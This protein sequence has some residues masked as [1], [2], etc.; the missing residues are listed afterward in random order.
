MVIALA[1]G[2]A[3]TPPPT[4]VRIQVK[5]LN[6]S[7]RD[8]F[9]IGENREDIRQGCVYPVFT[10]ADVAEWVTDRLRAPLGQLGYTVVESDGD[11]ALSGELR[12]FFVTETNHYDGQVELRFDVTLR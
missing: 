2:G 11:V 7:R 1:P 3:E 6:D 9:R 4:P 12:Q 10:H 8:A 5:P